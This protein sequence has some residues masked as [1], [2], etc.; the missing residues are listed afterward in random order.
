M[1]EYPSISLSENWYHDRLGVTF[2][3]DFWEDPVRRTENFM[4][5]DLEAERKFPGL[6]LGDLDPKP[7]PNP[8]QQYSHRFMAKLLGCEVVYTVDQAPSAVS[9]DCDMD[10]LC[11]FEMPDLQKNEVFKKA[12]ADAELLR[13]RFGFV[14]GG[15]NLG[16]PLNVAVT[17][18][19]AEFLACCAG[20]PEVARRV[21]MII[22]RT[23][24][25]LFYEFTK[26]VEPEYD[27][28]NLAVGYGNCPAIMLSPDLYREV[29][30]PIDLWYRQ[31]AGSFDLHHCGIFDNYAQLYTAL[32]PDSLDIGGLS[33]YKK[34]R[35]FFPDTPCVYIINPESLEGLTRE[36]IDA[37]VRQ[38][39]TDGGPVS[40]IKFIRS[41]GIGKN[42]TEDNIYDYRTS[43]LRQG[44][45]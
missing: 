33:D 17:V 44:F 31:Q 22:A 13:K 2:G 24:I 3:E 40:H 18:F 9:L 5:L 35:R 38:V 14:H 20:E 15:I 30:L 8:S 10:D 21:L 41:Y 16:S 26:A 1:R 42:M 6:G 25:R 45:I 36:Q 7:R 39:L 11:R 43:A 34:V 27:A 4:Q 29:V 23:Q 28:T 19:G 32:K 37:T 12:I